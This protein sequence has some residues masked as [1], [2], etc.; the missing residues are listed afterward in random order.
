MTSIVHRA[1]N[2][3]AAAVRQATAAY[4]K[5][6][7]VSKLRDYF[8]AAGFNAVSSGDGNAAW[9]LRGVLNRPESYGEHLRNFATLALFDNPQFFNYFS[10]E[11]TDGILSRIA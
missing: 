10:P 2:G 4:I 8:H 3:E 7:D 11:F 9:V 5:E 1:E 6:I